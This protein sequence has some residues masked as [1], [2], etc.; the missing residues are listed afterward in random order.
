MSWLIEGLETL[1]IREILVAMGVDTLQGM[2][3]AKPMR[4]AELEM[5]LAQCHVNPMPCNQCH[6]NL[7]LINPSAEFDFSA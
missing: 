3:Y 4:A 1:E 2:Y 7:M 6:V 5:N